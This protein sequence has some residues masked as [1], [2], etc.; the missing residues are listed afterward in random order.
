MANYLKLFLSFCKIGLFSIGGGYAALPLIQ[1]QIVEKHGWLTMNEFMDLIT[2]SEM[3]PGPIALNAASFIGLRLGGPLGV[4]V[5]SFANV[6]PSF[7]IVSFL[8][9]LYN[10][11]QELASVQTVIR[12]LRPTVVALIATAGLTIV[13]TALT[14]PGS[15][16]NAVLLFVSLYL[17]QTKRLGAIQ[18]IVL[19]GILGVLKALM[20]K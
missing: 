15:L 3:T 18:V 7:V 14:G 11:Y 8:A 19:T 9:Y 1:A 2:I 20:I 4:L 16:F 17:L 12:S 6:L 5:A 13:L 10:R